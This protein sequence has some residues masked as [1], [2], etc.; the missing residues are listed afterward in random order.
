M[1]R[2]EIKYTADNCS[3]DERIPLHRMLHYQCGLTCSWIGSSAR[4][5]GPGSGALQGTMCLKQ[6]LSAFS[7]SSTEICF[8]SDWKRGSPMSFALVCISL[9]RL[10]SSLFRRQILLHL[11]V[12]YSSKSKDCHYGSFCKESASTHIL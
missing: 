11:E 9:L 10:S 5:I 8:I 6:E 2:H 3:P 1:K 4:H 7:R 12:Y